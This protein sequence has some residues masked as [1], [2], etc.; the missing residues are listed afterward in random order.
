MWKEGITGYSF[1]EEDGSYWIGLL[2][3]KWI[4]N[5]IATYHRTQANTVFPHMV[6]RPLIAGKEKSRMGECD[7]QNLCSSSPVF[8]LLS[9]KQGHQGKTTCAGRFRSSV[10]VTCRVVHLPSND[11]DFLKTL[12][13]CLAGKGII[14]KGL[15][16]VQ[17]PEF[18]CL[19][20]LK[21]GFFLSVSLLLILN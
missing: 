7:I 1:W 5:T 6:P 10:S 13:S 2:S 14:N 16:V 9:N 8:S 20:M 19:M 18:S 21:S 3:C 12:I 15:A 17:M 11:F 4:Q